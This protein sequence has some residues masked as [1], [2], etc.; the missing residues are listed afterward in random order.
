MAVVLTVAKFCSTA[1]RSF[2]LAGKFG[3][4]AR[5]SARSFTV[6]PGFGLPGMN[7]VADMVPA[8]DIL[9]LARIAGERHFLL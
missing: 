4:P 8:D 1:H 6:S 2:P 9:A 3:A 7:W 5:I